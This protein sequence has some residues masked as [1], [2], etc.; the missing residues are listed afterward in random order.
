M[1]AGRT[2][3]WIDG[4]FRSPINSKDGHSVEDCIDPRE[5]RRVLEFVVPIVYPEKPR[6]GYQGDW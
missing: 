3:T 5:Q 6:Q 2:G 1:R 4:K